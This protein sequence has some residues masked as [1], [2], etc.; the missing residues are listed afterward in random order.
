[1]E[2]RSSSGSGG[3]SWRVSECG[4]ITETL[5]AMVREREQ[6]GYRRVGDGDGGLMRREV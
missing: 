5:E 4:L 2:G 6:S 3:L 1:M